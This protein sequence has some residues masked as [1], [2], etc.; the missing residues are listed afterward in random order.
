MKK[1]TLQFLLA[2]FCLFIN[3]IF[4]LSQTDH[5]HS[6][7]GTMGHLE[8][9]EKEYPEI[10][11]NR[12]KIEAHTQKALKNRNSLQKVNSVITIPVVVHVL[13]HTAQENISDA[14]ILSQIDVLNEDFRRLNADA[15]NTPA[16]FL[17]VAADIEIEFCLA[18]RDSNGNPSTG[19][20]RTYTTNTSWPFFYDMAFSSQGGVDA[21]NTGDY[22]NVWV[23]NIGGGTL[24][25]AQPPGGPAA[26]DGVVCDHR[27][28]GN[29]GYVEAPFDLGRTM[30]HEVGHWLN[31]RHIWGD[32]DCTVDD[33]VADTPSALF[34]NYT[35]SP[36]T[37]PDTN[38]CDDGVGDLPD[39]FQNYM[40]YS[41]DACFNLFTTGQKDRMRVLFEPGGFRESIL[42]STACDPLPAH[43]S[44]NIQ[45]SGETDVDCGG[46]CLPCVRCSDGI[47]NGEEVDI[48]CGG[49]DCLPCSGCTDSFAHNYNPISGLDDGSCETCTDNIQNADETGIDCGGTFC[50]PCREDVLEL[51][52][53]DI[54]I[55]SSNSNSNSNLPAFCGDSFFDVYNNGTWFSFEG[56]GEALI[57]SVD[58]AAT[59][60]SFSLEVLVEDGDELTCVTNGFRQLELVTQLGTT[61][62]LYL[63]QVFG[64]EAD[65]ELRMGCISCS[66]GIQDGDEE[67]V[68]CGGTFCNVCGD[69]CE[70]ALTLGCDATLIGSTNKSSSIDL[71]ATC[72]DDVDFPFSGVWF[73]FEG[74]GEDVYLSTDHA[75]TDYDTNL[76]LYSGDCNNLTCIEGNEDGGGTHFN[77]W[78]SELSFSS[79][80]GI[81]YYLYLSG[82]AGNRG[83]YELSRTC[84]TP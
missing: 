41:D 45:D 72:G 34:P 20:T 82:Y 9:L 58:F 32:G 51:A 23:C 6:R 60:G 36:C 18:T 79:E 25:Y 22:L 74:T 15:S 69:I 26:T 42:S 16:D 81:D 70:D 64:F 77:G 38:S 47:Q 61:Y 80:L 2:A 71:P 84:Y 56:T 39:M 67:G 48:D 17:P 83:N 46:S 30:T 14:Q 19:I 50:F 33:L 44:N 8:I 12:A 1:T 27:Y 53:G 7:C 21:W 35:F 54:V 10:I 28:F 40:D 5:D 76:Q 13:Y 55:G 65:F 43:C 63:Y 52:C 29:T 24:G 31:L 66:N 3:P 73:T 49:S 62:Y 57:L 11:K 78:T 59:N 68:D 37:Y 4:L 75:G